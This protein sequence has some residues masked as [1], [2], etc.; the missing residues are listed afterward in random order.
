MRRK[1]RQMTFGEVLPS[2]HRVMVP[3]HVVVIETIGRE[4]EDIVADMMRVPMDKSMVLDFTLGHV[5]GSRIDLTLSQEQIEM[6]RLQAMLNRRF[7]GQRFDFLGD[8]LVARMVKESLRMESWNVR[9]V[10]HD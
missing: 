2:F 3:I 6:I 4:I 8:S 1:T 7:R 9:M 10:M 5:P